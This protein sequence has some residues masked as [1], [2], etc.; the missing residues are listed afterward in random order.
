MQEVTMHDSHHAHVNPSSSREPLVSSLAFP[1]KGASTKRSKSKVSAT[2]II[3]STV[4]H[5]VELEKSLQNFKFAH[6]KV[7]LPDGRSTTLA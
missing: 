6:D 2:S 3:G 4:T 5:A 1:N 7:K